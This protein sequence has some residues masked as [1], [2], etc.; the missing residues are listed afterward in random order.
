MP[1]EKK[2]IEFVVD[3]YLSKYLNEIQGI[4]QLDSKIFDNYKP[5]IVI[6]LA[7]SS[8]KEIEES[9]KEKG[10]NNFIRFYDLLDKMKNRI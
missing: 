10:I 4:K 8:A 1:L 6:I 9:L 5:D 2:N 7:R 3:N